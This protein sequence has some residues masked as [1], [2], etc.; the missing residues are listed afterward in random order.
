MYPEINIKRRVLDMVFIA[1]MLMALIALTSHP[2]H[3]TMEFKH[4]ESR[5]LV[6]Q[7]STR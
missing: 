1:A 5:M 7:G 6:E 2:A 3:S 4:G